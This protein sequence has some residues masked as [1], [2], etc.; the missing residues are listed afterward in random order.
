MW[1]AGCEVQ[2]SIWV[3]GSGVKGYGV[4]RVRMYLEEGAG[5]PPQQQGRA[6]VLGATT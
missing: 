5:G 1:V 2:E 6:E 4:R 3:Q